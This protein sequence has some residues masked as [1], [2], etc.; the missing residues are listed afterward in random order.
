MVA[1]NTNGY[2]SRTTPNPN[3][4]V[5]VLA[6][7]VRRYFRRHPDVAPEKFLV[8]A[9]GRELRRREGW[10]AAGRTP[11]TEEDIRIH[12]WLNQRLAALHRERHGFGARIR[13]F[14]LRNRLLRWLSSGR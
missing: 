9:V 11:L 2:V 1:L 6:G 12:V 4:P 8:D 14:F 5:G 3:L 13:R 10:E 7:R